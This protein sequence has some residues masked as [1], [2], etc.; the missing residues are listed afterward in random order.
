MKKKEITAIAY[1]ITFLALLAFALPVNA[2]TSSLDLQTTPDYYVRSGDNIT[3]T[4]APVNVS[5]DDGSIGRLDFYLLDATDHFLSNLSYSGTAWNH[6]YIS[7]YNDDHFWVENVSNQ[8]LGVTFNVSN[9]APESTQNLVGFI[10]YTD[11]DGSI[12]AVV[13]NK[14]LLPL[15]DLSNYIFSRIHID[16]T[17]PSLESVSFE[18]PVW[19][20][21]GLR[22]T[23]IVND[24]SPLDVVELHYTG[25]GGSGIIALNPTASGY[26][27]VIP[28]VHLQEG[29]PISYFISATDLPGNNLESQ[30][31]QY[32]PVDNP[33][34]NSYSANTSL[35]NQDVIITAEA[36]DLSPLTVALSYSVDGQERNPVLL[37]EQGN[38]VYTRNLGS[39]S[40]G[41]AID[42]TITASDP[43]GGQVTRSDS[44]NILN[45]YNVTLNVEDYIL[46]TPIDDVTVNVSPLTVTGVANYTVP[47]ETL[48]FDGS[49]AFMQYEGQYNYTASAVGYPARIVSL[50]INEDKEETI[51]L[52][53]E[54]ELEFGDIF[55]EGR[56]S[57]SR[58]SYY[59]DVTVCVVDAYPANEVVLYYSLEDEMLTNMQELESTEQFNCYSSTLGPSST[60]VIAYSRLQVEDGQGELKEA[61]IPPHH[62]N[63]LEYEG[64]QS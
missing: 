35:P 44:F 40:G 50:T 43:Y 17:P 4:F 60:S 19:L 27:G 2:Q 51:L 36:E 61:E 5:D 34:I 38:N 24:A 29:S 41:E 59:L 54:S 56:L 25:S 23:A 46:L 30:Q 28:A 39:F 31:Q 16:N 15:N 7:N 57:E 53:I 20:S 9:S 63:L 1:A 14:P 49:T 11:F 13:D 8:G 22:V 64:G 6:E 21:D 10:N 58:Q 32:T 33:R 55:I 26:R 47:G 12:Q 48:Q 62:F 45:E 3:L 37:S 18:S 52:G 42:F